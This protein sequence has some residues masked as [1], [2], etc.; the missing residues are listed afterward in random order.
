MPKVIIWTLESDYD[1]QAVECLANKL[2]THLEIDNISI[3]TIGKSAIPRRSRKPSTEPL[4]QAVRNYLRDADCI[5][6]IFVLDSDGPMASHKRQQEPNSLIN[7]VK[8]VL[9]DA[10]FAGKTHKAPAVCE[11]EAWLLIDCAGIF[12]Y[13]ARK[14][15]KKDCRT[16]T[17]KRRDLSNVIKKHQKGDTEL[18]V[19]AAMGGKGVKEYL[20]KFSKIILLTMNPKMP[21]KNISREKYT[22]SMS[23]AIAQYVVIN[24]TTLRRNRSLRRL[25]KLIA[26][27]ARVSAA[28]RA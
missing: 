17:E 23:P 3:T 25:G 10:E 2:I 24:D 1:A 15:L 19:E 12:C 16:R 9:Q 7:Q 28:G 21:S 14:R 6:V 11:L 8:S 13:F 20:A 27:C 26:D 5:C 18:I 22:E 4:K